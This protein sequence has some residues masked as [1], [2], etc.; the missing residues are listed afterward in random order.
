[1]VIT[2]AKYHH[3][4]PVTSAALSTSA[5]A[6]TKMSKIMPLTEI[7]FTGFLVITFN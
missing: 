5:L 6:I 1:M 2:N 7:L 4:F 3:S